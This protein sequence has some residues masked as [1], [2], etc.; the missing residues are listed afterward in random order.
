MALVKAAK[1][2]HA[3]ILIVDS[4][5]LDP[6]DLQFLLGARAF[7]DFAVVL[8]SDD[9]K[10]KYSDVPVDRVVSRSNTS[11]R[12]FDA[13]GELGGVVSMVSRPYIRESRRGYGRSANELSRREY[14]CAQ[15]VAKGMSNRKIAHITGLRE[16]SV[17][18][19][20]SV[21]MRKLNC[22]NR[23]QVALKLTQGGTSVEPTDNSSDSSGS[24]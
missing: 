21:V 22:E 8:I 9:S 16:Q 1:E 7:G 13:L 10:D 20:V 17:K 23:V 19:L 11:S 3:H 4:N 15:L 14:E 2:Q 24:S 6:N 12:L 18:N 5:G